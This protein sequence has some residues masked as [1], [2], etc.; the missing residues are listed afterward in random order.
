M[1][2]IIYSDASISHLDSMIRLVILKDEG[3]GKYEKTA[4]A[5]TFESKTSIGKLE[6]LGVFYALKL[7]EHNSIIYTDSETVIRELN[8]KNKS[9]WLPKD[10]LEETINLIKQKNCK[11]LWINRSKNLAG[12]DLQK[13]LKESTLNGAFKRNVKKFGINHAYHKIK[14]KVYK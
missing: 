9:D 13:R 4:K 12:I 11:V 3:N 2:D 14:R 6:F 10:F 5:K 1:C 7:A 8:K